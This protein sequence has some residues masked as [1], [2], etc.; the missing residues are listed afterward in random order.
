[1]KMDDDTLASEYGFNKELLKTLSYISRLKKSLSPV[2]ITSTSE[3][4]ETFNIG[5]SFVSIRIRIIIFPFRT[6]LRPQVPEY[7]LHYRSPFPQQH[8][9]RQ[10][11]LCGLPVLRHC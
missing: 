11:V 8:R 4:M 3:T 9:K 1:M 5:W 6:V 10:P 7:H 2:R